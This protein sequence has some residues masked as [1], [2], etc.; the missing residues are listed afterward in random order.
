MLAT[1]IPILL[2][3]PVTTPAKAQTSTVTVEYTINANDR[4]AWSGD[5]HTGNPNHEVRINGYNS[6]NEP[7][8][9]VGNDS[10]AESAGME[11]RIAVP[12]GA[13]IQ[14]AFITVKAGSFQSTSPTGAMIIHLYNVANAQPFANGFFGDLVNHHPTYAQT[15]S[16]NANTTWTNGSV[17]QTPNISSLIQTFVSRADY[18]PGNYIGFAITGGTIESGKYYGWE[19]YFAG[20]TPAKLTISYL[21]SAAATPTKTPTSTATAMPTATI[22]STPTK[23]PS[24]TPTHTPMATQLPNPT[25]ISTPAS[26]TTTYPI[27]ANNRDAVSL[28]S[29]GSTH[30]IRISGYGNGSTD[31][32]NYVSSDNE[33]E[34]AAMEFSVNLPSGAKI[35]DAYVTVKAGAYQNTSPT[36]AMSIHLYD[37]ANAAPFVNGLK[38]D[39]VEYQPTYSS[40]II[41]PAGTSW[42]PGSVHQTP[43]LASFV[44]T[45][46]NRP[47]YA[48]GNYI[49]FVITEGTL[50][51]NR[52]YGWQD[53]TSAGNGAVLTVTYTS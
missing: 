47:D 38:G 39:L 13:T 15:A 10:D 51:Q 35:T 32:A 27:T 36:G 23:A 48:S 43:N 19:D 41:W 18:A 21:T 12:P 44:Q 31:T 11:F 24:I 7:Y 49:G 37:T 14:N 40:T 17:Q 50:E 8:E 45:F 5:A 30:E 26:V 2:F 33:Q 34:S 22:T 9:F 42:S 4:D 1:V 53:S 46:I 3:L 16:W 29:G 20:G 28:D 52:Y 6:T 25:A